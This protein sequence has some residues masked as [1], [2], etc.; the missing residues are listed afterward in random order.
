MVTALTRADWQKWAQR[1]GNAAPSTWR[2]ALNRTLGVPGTNHWLDVTRYCFGV[3]N[4]LTANPPQIIAVS[5]YWLWLLLEVEP[6][7]TMELLALPF[8]DL[9]NIAKLGNP[10]ASALL[11][12]K[13]IAVNRTTRRK[14]RHNL[15]I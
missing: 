14:Q 6:D 4:R 13:Y 11:P 2:G 9:I 10:M 15:P 7:A 5:A 8:G 12:A 1:S 3:L